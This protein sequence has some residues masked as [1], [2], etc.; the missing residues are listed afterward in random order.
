MVP[1]PTPRLGSII[2]KSQGRTHIIYDIFCCD[3]VLLMSN[4][5]AIVLGICACVRCCICT[6]AFRLPQYSLAIGVQSWS[7]GL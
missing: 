7:V 4:V 6:L 3:M 2:K 1:P 5:P